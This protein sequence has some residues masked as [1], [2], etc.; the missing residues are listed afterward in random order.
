MLADAMMRVRVIS[1]YLR[2]MYFFT[3]PH[4]V[5]VRIS[6]PQIFVLHRNVSWSS[7]VMAVEKM[8]HNR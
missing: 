6:T 1:V 8:L 3:A 7:V 5:N 4:I 2:T